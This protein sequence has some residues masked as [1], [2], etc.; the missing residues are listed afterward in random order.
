MI[1]LRMLCFNQGPEHNKRRCLKDFGLL[2]PMITIDCFSS[3]KKDEG[4]T[5][6]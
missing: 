6:S 1:V 4:K 2:K 5:F 3:Q